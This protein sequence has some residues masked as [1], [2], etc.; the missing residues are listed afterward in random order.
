MQ[1]KRKNKILKK[2]KGDNLFFF[3]RFFPFCLFFSRFDKV[4]KKNSSFASWLCDYSAVSRG[5]GRD[6]RLAPDPKSLAKSIRRKRRTISFIFLFFFFFCGS[7][8]W[9][10][11]LLL[12]TLKERNIKHTEDELTL[13]CR[14]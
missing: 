8:L 5:S 1:N 3:F 10:L 4:R 9:C 7:P 12:Q 14:D 11:L 6:L 2:K 13:A